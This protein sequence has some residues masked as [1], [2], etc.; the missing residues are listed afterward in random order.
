MTYE[1]IATFSQVTSLLMFIAM[2]IVIVAYAMWPK[3]KARFE[4]IQR[5]ALDLDT[6]ATRRQRGQR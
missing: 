1:T 3:N 5:S 6:A 2:F 4:A